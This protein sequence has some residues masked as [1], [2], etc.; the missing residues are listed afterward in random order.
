MP[1]A[2][3]DK[4]IRSICDQ[5]SPARFLFSR[6]DSSFVDTPD[7]DP[8]VARDYLDKIEKAEQ[9]LTSS[10]YYFSQ[11]KVTDFFFSILPKLNKSLS[12]CTV[13]HQATSPAIRGR[14]LWEKTKKQQLLRSNLFVCKSI[15]ATHNTPENQLLKSYLFEVKEVVDEIIKIVGTGGITREIIKIKHATDAYIKE[16]KMRGVAYKKKP[17]QA[18]HRG[19][20]R[21]KQRGY[22][23]LS[24]LYGKLL[25]TLR[26]KKIDT[27]ID[28]ISRGW[29]EP[30]RDDDLF[31]IYILVLLLNMLTARYGTPYKF[32]GIGSLS[33]KEVVKWLIKDSDVSLSLYFD[34]SPES[35]TGC[36]YLYT[37]IASKYKGVSVRPRRPDLTLRFQGQGFHRFLLVEAK[38]TRD[39][40]YINES[41]YKSVAYLKDFEAIWQ[42]DYEQK[43]K[44]ILIFPESEITKISTSS[45]A[46]SADDLEILSSNET[47]RIARLISSLIDHQHET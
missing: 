41:I 9:V 11:P 4:W 20:T 28:L 22:S 36:P 13:S 43:P 19:A 40:D 23:E 7:I 3:R 14:I 33:R 35:I 44:I 45:E 27:I 37:K 42:R 2:V 34:Q 6:K 5:A 1:G 12:R 16:S 31:E 18:M 47:E 30:I 25:Q 46:E 38:M 24:L 15:S 21:N 8:D 26:Q 17:T 10:L 39:K 32:N 29:F